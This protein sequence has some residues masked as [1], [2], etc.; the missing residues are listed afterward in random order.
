MRQK[1]RSR[2]RTPT[3]D[4]ITQAILDD[5][6]LV[7]FGATRRGLL[8]FLN[9]ANCKGDIGTV[10]LDAHAVGHLVA[11]LKALAP[12]SLKTPTPPVLEGAD[13]DPSAQT[14]F[15]PDASV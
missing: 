12:E 4:D 15:L 5:A 11:V 9:I 7:G 3:E 6:C 8:I 2:V 14:G 10:F 13:G 1:V